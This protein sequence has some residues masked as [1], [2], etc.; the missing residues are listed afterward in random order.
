MLNSHIYRYM[1]SENCSIRILNLEA[2]QAFSK[3]PLGPPKLWPT[4]QHVGSISGLSVFQG[5]LRT[6][7]IAVDR[8]PT[9]ISCRVR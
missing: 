1:Y 2:D 4:M 7:K 5:S 3:D 6:Y 8:K 9:K